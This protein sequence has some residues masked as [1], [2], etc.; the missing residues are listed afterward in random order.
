[1][2]GLFITVLNMSLTASYVALVVIIIRMLLGKSPKIFS[3]VI[4]A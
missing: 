3:Y 2:S 1:M 4:W